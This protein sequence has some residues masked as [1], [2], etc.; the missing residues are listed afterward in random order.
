[1]RVRLGP[2]LQQPVERLARIEN[3]SASNMTEKLIAAG[4]RSLGVMA[5]MEAPSVQ[6]DRG[7]R[8]SVPLSAA[9]RTTIKRLAR[10]EDRSNRSM[11]H[12][13]LIAG[14]RVHGAWPPVADAQHATDA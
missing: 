8:M 1:M 2:E 14:L 4:L 12:Q 13:L 5:A 3:R 11:A 10:D 7:C 6:S 9:E